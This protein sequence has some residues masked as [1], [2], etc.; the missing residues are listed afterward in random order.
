MLS[1]IDFERFD[2]ETAYYIA[3]PDKVKI[4]FAQAKKNAQLFISAPELLQTLKELY[5]LTQNL[6]H[7]KDEGT[8]QKAK[9]L[10]EKHE[11]TNQI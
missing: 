7:Y 8:M 5:T 3:N 6:A 10:I 9:Q 1:M 11:T 4:T 2:H